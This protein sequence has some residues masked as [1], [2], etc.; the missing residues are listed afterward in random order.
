MAYNT[1]INKT[2]RNI[3]LGLEH[4]WFKVTVKKVNGILTMY[5]C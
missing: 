2:D 1:S 5:F 3:Y 4:E